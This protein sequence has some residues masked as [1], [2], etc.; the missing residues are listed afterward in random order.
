MNPAWV[1]ALS[2]AQHVLHQ[3]L[4]LDPKHEQAFAGLNGR[5]LCVVLKQPHIELFVEFENS[6]PWLSAHG[7]A[8]D[9]TL[10]GDLSALVDTA[11]NLARGNSALVMEGLDVAGSV[12]VLKGISDGFSK[13]DIDLED[14]LS[15][16]LG[17]PI[18]G[19]LLT[20][21]RA[22]WRTL[23]EQSE[24]AKAQ[25]EEFIRHEQTWLLTRER[26]ESFVDRSRRLR[27]RIERL[28]RKL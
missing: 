27:H 25:G 6:L 15:K 5:T 20:G 2:A 28:E 21:V 11:R 24:Q 12:G 9:V 8:P 10:S 23:K 26:F 1:M 19:T 7:A 17:D 22:I 4:K 16:K 18:A 14:E 3:V 13:L